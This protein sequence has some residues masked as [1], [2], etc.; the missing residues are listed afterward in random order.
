MRTWLRWVDTNYGATEIRVY[1]DTQTLDTQNLPDPLA[2]LGPKVTEYYH[3]NIDTNFNHYYIVSAIV[4][5]VEY[6]APEVMVEPDDND[7]ANFFALGE[8][9]WWYDPSD[10]G[11][12][13]QDTGGTIAV[14]ADGDPVRRLLD[15]SGNG[16][17][18]SH[19]S[20]FIYRTDGTHHWLELN[21]SGYLIGSGTRPL[22]RFLHAPGE[23]FTGCYGVRFG[24]VDNPNDIYMLWSNH[25]GTSSRVG[26]TS[27]WDDRAAQNFYDSFRH[28]QGRGSSSAVI[29]VPG[30]SSSP[31][32]VPANVD[33]V[34]S[35]MA[36]PS[37]TPVERHRYRLAG[38]AD[39]V[40]N[41]SNRNG[42]PLNSDPTDELNLG[43][44][45]G[46]A[47][48]MVGRIYQIVVVEGQLGETQ[49]GQLEA[50]VSA[51]TPAT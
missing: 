44:S 45:S 17:H 42:S 38:E 22:L 7:I 19:S 8:K 43:R 15:K 21:G 10:L 16:I 1:H 30:L 50:A 24:N 25:G 3:E 23:G 2:V 18:L 4:N 27:G 36:E 51:K 26:A 6:F 46:G 34:L 11:T 39:L 49:R 9:G 32:P 28:W 40:L 5:G 48:N 29:D 14:T 47:S 12:M 33:H 31:G 37:A 13:Y 20:G 41:P 35:E